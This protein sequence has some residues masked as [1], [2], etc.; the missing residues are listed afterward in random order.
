MRDRF[1]ASGPKACAMRFHAQTAGS[2]L[3]AQQPD[4]NIVR[5]SVQALAAVLGGA[6]SLHTN[7]K[8]EALGLPTEPAARTALRT[9]Q[10]LAFESGVSEVVDPLGGSW[11]V[12]KLTC[13]L[14]DEAQEYL[15]TIRSLGGVLRAIES[16]YIQREIQEAAYDHQK[17]LESVQKI[18]VGVNRFQEEEQDN[19]GSFRVDPTVETQQVEKLEELRRG[20]DCDRVAATL[21]S[22]R[23][24]ANGRENLMPAIISAVE[25]SATVGEIADAMRDAFGE[26]Q[27]AIVL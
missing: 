9:Q 14:E 6:Q 11:Y 13:D 10:V 22:I 20:R 23:R 8:D 4:N 15:D 17:C 7:A 5:V 3:T 16:G 26:H 2:T 24:V 12:E 27:E 19:I 18:V 25:A 1:K 21:D